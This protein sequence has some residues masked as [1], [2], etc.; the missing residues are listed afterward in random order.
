MKLNEIAPDELRKACE[1]VERHARSIGK[2]CQIIFTN[3]GVEIAPLEW[4][5]SETADNLF[6]AVQQAAKSAE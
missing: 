1:I 3:K 5:G 2:D 4:A 6:L